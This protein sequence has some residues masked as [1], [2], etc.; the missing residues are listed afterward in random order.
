M[1]NLKPVFEQLFRQYG[2]L[3]QTTAK[4]QKVLFAWTSAAHKTL[5][6]ISHHFHTCFHSLCRQ[7]GQGVLKPTPAS[8]LHSKVPTFHPGLNDKE[9][10]RGA[11]VSGCARK[12]KPGQLKISDISPSCLGKIDTAAAPHQVNMKTSL[13]PAGLVPAVPATAI[14]VPRQT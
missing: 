4:N 10:A 14:A 13:T 3:K 8:A 6:S 9:N 1:Y 2:A 7:N 12:K 11:H 5:L